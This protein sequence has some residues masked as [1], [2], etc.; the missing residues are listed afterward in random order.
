MNR[1]SVLQ[2]NPSVVR[3][4]GYELAFA[5]CFSQPQMTHHADSDEGDRELIQ[6]G[7]RFAFSLSAHHHDAEDLVQQAWLRCL[8]R[9]GRVRKRAVLFATIRNLHYD[10]WR[11][12][13]VVAFSSVPDLGETTPSAQPA[14]DASVS[15]DL[16]EL[17]QGLRP[18]ER[19]ALYLHSVEGWTAKE[20]SSILE[21]PRN[22]ILSLIHRARRKLEELMQ[23]PPAKGALKS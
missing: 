22:T 16:E 17:L 3:L 21:K 2:S 20:I 12:G 19:E 5:S 11:R 4:R 14:P 7:Y 23:E 18:E 9:Y 13:R 15:M 10:H 8:K 6:A 1:E